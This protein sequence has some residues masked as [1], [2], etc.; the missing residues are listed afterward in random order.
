MLGGNKMPR[1]RSLNDEFNIDFSFLITSNY[2]SPPVKTFKI[3][4]SGRI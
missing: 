4:F 2:L 1:G 3:R